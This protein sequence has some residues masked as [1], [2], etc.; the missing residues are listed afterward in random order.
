MQTTPPVVKCSCDKQTGG[1]TAL[2]P[3]HCAGCSSGVERTTQFHCQ[4]CLLGA[5]RCESA[6]RSISPAV[7]PRLP[8]SSLFSPSLLKV[9]GGN[10]EKNH[11]FF[12][13]A[14]NSTRLHKI[15]RKCQNETKRHDL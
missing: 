13:T 6:R 7:R 14:E 3:F 8:S 15:H 2:A 4:V 5:A 12:C 1:V 10:D 9:N 11:N